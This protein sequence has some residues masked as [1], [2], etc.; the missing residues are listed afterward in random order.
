ML[1]WLNFLFGVFY[2]VVFLIDLFTQH[3]SVT[4]YSQGFLIGYCIS[5]ISREISTPIPLLAALAINA[6]AIV[7]DRNLW[8]NTLV[9]LV[10]W[11][12][13]TIVLTT[14]LVRSKKRLLTDE[15]FDAFHHRWFLLLIFLFDFFLLDPN[16]GIVIF[17][18]LHIQHPLF[19]WDNIILLVVFI[20]TLAIGDYYN[21]VLTILLGL[22]ISTQMYYGRRYRVLPVKE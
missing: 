4:F 19:V 1:S 10:E 11:V 12:H 15:K 6:F 21:F 14:F 7:Y 17:I 22:L 18:V 16:L 3:V 9:L 8:I 13:F 2:L 20:Y 5:A